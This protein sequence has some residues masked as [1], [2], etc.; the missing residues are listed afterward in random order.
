MT[1]TES[2]LVLNEINLYGTGL[3]CINQNPIGMERDYFNGI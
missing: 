2:S 1:G 3:I